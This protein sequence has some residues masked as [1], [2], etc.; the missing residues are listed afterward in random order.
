MITS[1]IRRLYFIVIALPVGFVLF[2]LGGWALTITVTLILCLAAYEYG[3]VF[4]LGGVHPSRWVLIGG[5][6]VLVLARHLTG[7]E[8]AA[9]LLSLLI[10]ISMAIH[11]V[12]YE[13]G[14]D[15]AASDFAATLA[16]ILYFGWLGGYFISLRSLPDGM[17]WIILALVSTW[18]VDVGGYVVGRPFGKH[19][20]SPRLSPRKTWEGYVGGIFG[21][22]LGSVLVVVAWNAIEPSSAAPVQLWQAVLLGVVL[23]ILTPLGDLGESMVKRQFG[24]K[25]SSHLIPGHGGVWDRIDSWLW[26]V[27]LGYYFIVWLILS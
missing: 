4:E 13:R 23:G 5:T 1:L 9:W 27:A 15:F 26:G 6:A 22:I 18:M 17:W 12:T 19:H 10:F 20:F 21:G 16:G 24:V 7:F 14:R 8:S 2:I 11:L 25:D 3:K